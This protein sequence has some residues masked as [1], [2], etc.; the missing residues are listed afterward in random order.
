VVGLL[1]AEQLLLAKHVQHPAVVLVS[2]LGDD[3]TDLATLSQVLVSYAQQGIPLKVIAL[4]PTPAN[5]KFF[6]DALGQQNAIAEARLPTAAEAS[7]KLTLSAAFPIPLAALA[8]VLLPLLP[9]LRGA[10]ADGYAT[11]TPSNRR[12]LPS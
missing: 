10:R 5:A 2:D 11:A 9:G 6:Q 4:D 12:A 1:L 3:P 7:G 8:G